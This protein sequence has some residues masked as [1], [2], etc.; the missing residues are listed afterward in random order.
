MTDADPLIP[1]TAPPFYASPLLD[2]TF[3][4]D[5]ISQLRHAVAS[6]AGAAGLEGQRRD[7][8][9]LAVNELITNAVRHGGGSGQLRLWC[10][11]RSVL[12]EVSD[13]GTG[14]HADRLGAQRQ[15]PPDT[16]GGWGLWLAEQLSDAMRVRTSPTGTTVRISS[17]IGQAEPAE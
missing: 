14:I 17:T 3:D 5:R 13:N 11:G 9:V 15:P 16:T 1:G 4:R 10:E 2:E 7:D 6:W 8:F 12:C